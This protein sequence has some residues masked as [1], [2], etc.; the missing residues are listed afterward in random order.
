MAEGL[1]SVA[2]CFDHGQSVRLNFTDKDRA[3][4]AWT[5]IRAKDRGPDD[6]EIEVCDDYG[7]RIMLDRDNVTFVTLE[8]PAKLTEAEI[9]RSLIIARGNAKANQRAQNDPVLKFAAT[10]GGLQMQRA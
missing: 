2:V 8:D 7:V 6:F 5:A 1:Y 9:E 4:A 3:E 10:A